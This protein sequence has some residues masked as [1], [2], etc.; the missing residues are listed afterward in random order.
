M[1]NRYISTMRDMALLFDSPSLHSRHNFARDLHH[2]A[3]FPLPVA[4]LLFTLPLSLSLSLPFPLPPFPPSLFLLS[5]QSTSIPLTHLRTNTFTPTLSLSHF[6][7]LTPPIP[8]SIF[9]HHHP[10]LSLHFNT[11]PHPLTIN[12]SPLP[13]ACLP[14]DVSLFSLFTLIHAQPSHWPHKQPTSLNTHPS[15][16]LTTYSPL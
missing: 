16:F 2:H 15:V 7:T 5:L 13:F 4:F 9:L 1:A 12:D 6:C 3:D 10:P 8:L 14:P 11:N